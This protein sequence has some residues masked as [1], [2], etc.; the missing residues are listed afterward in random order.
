[1]TWS[2]T[3]SRPDIV[4]LDPT[5]RSLPQ[6]LADHVGR[7]SAAGGEDSAELQRRT[8][9]AVTEL[10]GPGR[11]IAELDDDERAAVAVLHA[12]SA[13]LALGHAR[14]LAAAVAAE[15]DPQTGLGTRA[16][17]LVALAEARSTE[18]A[19]GVLVAD[20]DAFARYAQ[21]HGE[22][23]AG[24][25]LRATGAA[26]QTALRRGDELF[27]LGTDS[28][29]GLLHT[30]REDEALDVARRLHSAV[31]FSGAGVGLS[32]GVA[33]AYEAEDD[34]ALLA[35]AAGTVREVKGEGRNR[36]RLAPEPG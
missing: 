20:L 5:T 13:A 35:R 22:G 25:A 2:A 7:L 4:D 30:V 11:P 31:A 32:V 26:L 27:R 36:V 14:A 16:A 1:M 23:A 21:R 28:F 33:V 18:A 34:L 19:V 3:F 10:V 15:R 8:A 17:F 24:R 29:V 12:H 9:S 6:R